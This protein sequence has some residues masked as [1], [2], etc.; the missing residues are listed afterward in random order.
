MECIK[1]L[2]RTS[3][4]A[5]IHHRQPHEARKSN[6]RRSLRAKVNDE[7][8]SLL[9]QAA[10]NA[11]SLRFRETNRP[12]NN[13][14]FLFFSVEHLIDQLVCIFESLFLLCCCS[15]HRASLSRPIRRLL[16]RESWWFRHERIL[17]RLFPRNQIH[18]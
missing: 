10:I 14:Y 13:Q 17:A 16:R 7:N 15:E 1:S 11:A 18:R 6:L 8:D 5:F 2:C 9:L 3:A 4:T 12:G